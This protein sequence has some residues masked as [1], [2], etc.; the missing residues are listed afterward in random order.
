MKISGN[1]QVKEGDS[2]K[3]GAIVS[4]ALNTTS[5]EL[6]KYKRSNDNIK[7][8]YIKQFGNRYDKRL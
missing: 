4:L 7:I 5:D 8:T 6:K 3:N 2:N 1:T